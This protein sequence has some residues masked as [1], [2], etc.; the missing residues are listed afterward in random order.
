MRKV[1]FV[2]YSI[3]SWVYRWVVMFGILWFLSDFLGPKLKILS[4]ILAFASLGSLFIWPMY[5][6]VKNISQRGRLPDMKAPRV[7]MTLTALGALLAAFFFLPLPVS[8]VHETGMVVVNP[9]E[10]QGVS[11]PE[12]ARLTSLEVQ[13]GQEV[14]KG[15]I[16]GRFTSEQLEVE[17]ARALANQKE[18][19][20][21]AERLNR[22]V[23]EAKAAGDDANAKRYQVDA[24]EAESKAIAAIVQ[25]KFLNDRS[26][27]VREL[28]APRDGV[29]LAAPQPDEIG[30]LFDRGIMDTQPIFSVG[31]PNRLLVRVPVNPPDYKLLKDD[32]GTLKDLDVSI[33]VKGR[34][35]HEFHGTLSRL[36]AQNSETVPVQLTQRGG[37]PLAIKPGGDPNVFVPLAQVYLV[38]VDVTDPDGA[39][40][41]GQLAIVK[42]H[43]EWR[44][45]AW[46][47]GRAL[48][49][50]LDI[51][52]Y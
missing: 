49:N 5:R 14:R 16:L 8:R 42:I 24:Q 13:P 34:S 12:P 31:D 33:L 44:S 41:L 2:T 29:V 30:K 21:L 17:K 18:Q 4:Q 39:V 25:L 45:G 22:S 10:A 47:V 51:G 20:Q 9:G 3:A 35:D 38:D 48:A 19:R 1:L 37:G 43:T 28:R 40:L 50:A 11:L 6:I 27:K 7:Y 15:Q 23:V 26:D 32:L 46:W 52:L 36:P